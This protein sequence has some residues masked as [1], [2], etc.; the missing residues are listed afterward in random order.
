MFGFSIMPS[1][2]HTLRI[3]MTEHGSKNPL[4]H[5]A[6]A[7]QGMV[8][9]HQ[10]LWLDHG[11]YASLLAQCRVPSQRLGVG[12]DATHSWEC[13]P[14]SDITARHFAKRAPIA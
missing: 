13:H 12:V 9:L 4:G 8:T 10:Q 11:D 3:E 6:A 5:L 7:L 2:L 1:M 14:L